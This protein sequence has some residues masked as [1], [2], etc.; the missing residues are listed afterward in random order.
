M[1]RYFYTIS[2]LVIAV[3]ANAQSTVTYNHD[4]AKM[5]QMTVAA[6]G[7]GSLTPTLYYDM[8]HSSYAKQAALKN[9][10]AF[11]TTAGVASYAQV[12]AAEQLDSAL[13]KRAEVEALNVADRSGGVLDLAWA[14]EGTKIESKMADYEKNI[15]RILS[16]GGTANEQ[17]HWKEYYNVYQSAIKA[18]QSGY[19]P[20]SERKKQYLQIYADVAR[21]NEA[22][23]KYIV[24]LSNAKSTASLLAATY[25]KTDSKSAIVVSAMS[26]WREAGWKVK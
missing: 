2:L 12:D 14:A 7:T 22:L 23:I 1:K 16:V 3:T 15:N 5:N 9:M 24:Q 6:I 4:S 20:N 17:T 8:L 19:M 18:A 26:R 25:A 10:L 11:R 13:V 21:K